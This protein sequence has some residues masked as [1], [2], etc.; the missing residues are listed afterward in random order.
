MNPLLPH[1]SL[2]SFFFPVATRGMAAAA[3]PL[4]PGGGQLSLLPKHHRHLD[5]ERRCEL[6]RRPATWPPVLAP[7]PDQP[8][9]IDDE[10]SQATE[11]RK[12]QQRG[13]RN[14][15][16]PND[17]GKEHKTEAAGREEESSVRID[18]ARSRRD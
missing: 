14:R 2:A 15:R 3:L 5:L 10:I 8:R 1:G 17:K 11:T 9:S 12:E 16:L 4:K 18:L 7:R 13:I 6:A